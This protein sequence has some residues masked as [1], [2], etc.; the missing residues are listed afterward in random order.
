MACSAVLPVVH[1][2][3]AVRR[4]SMIPGALQGNTAAGNESGYG[5][6]V[7][8]SDAR[9]SRG[10]STVHECR[11]CRLALVVAGLS[12]RAARVLVT[13]PGVQTLMWMLLRWRTPPIS[14]LF[15]VPLRSRL[16]VVALLPKASRNRY[17]NSAATNGCSASSDIASSISTAFNFAS[18]LLAAQKDFT[19]SGFSV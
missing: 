12:F 3:S 13:S 15:E 16:M 18:P 14:E 4:Y 10:S 11:R 2:M 8:S 6:T 1:E 9:R 5:A 17:G 19:L 7:R